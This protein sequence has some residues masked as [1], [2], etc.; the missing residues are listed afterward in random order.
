MTLSLL[1]GSQLQLDLRGRKAEN[2][3]GPGLAPG[4]SPSLMSNPFLA[5]LPL[6]VD[7]QLYPPCSGS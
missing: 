3:D 5:C 7:G 4:V 6:L 2:S 1:S